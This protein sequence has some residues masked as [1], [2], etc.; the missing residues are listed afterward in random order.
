MGGQTFGVGFADSKLGDDS[1]IVRSGHRNLHPAAGDGGAA[2]LSQRGAAA[3]GCPRGVGRWRPVRRGLR[4]QSPGHADPVTPLPV[5]CR[6]Q[7]R[8]TAGDCRGA[9]DRGIRY[10]CGGEHRLT[11]RIIRDGADG[12]DHPHR[13]NDQRR[14]PLSFTTSGTNQ[15]SIAVPT[16]PGWALPGYYMVFAINSQGTPVGG[17]DRAAERRPCAASA[18]HL[19]TN[20]QRS[21]AAIRCGSPGS[22]PDA[23][24]LTYSASVCPMACRSMQ[25]PASCPAHRPMPAAIPPPSTPPTAAAGI[26]TNF[27]FTVAAAG[28]VRFVRLEELSEVNANPWG[29]AAEVNLLRWR[30]QPAQSQ[31]AGP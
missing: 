6:R 30:R 8:H 26:S 7:R 14:I 15:Y 19:T 2:Q 9:V 20:T 21:A 10:Q 18:G 13:H 12:L 4:G 24:A 29:S 5:Q 22:H 17:K 11:G 3:S 31:A 1:R 28:G 25:P 23:A 16:N 27:S